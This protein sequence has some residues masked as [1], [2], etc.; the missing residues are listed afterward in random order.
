MEREVI[1]SNVQ[2]IQR[3]LEIIASSHNDDI[4]LSHFSNMDENLCAVLGAFHKGKSV[5]IKID[6]E[7]PTKFKNNLFIRALCPETECEKNIGKN[8]IPYF[9]I[10]K[11]D[12]NTQNQ[13]VLDYIQHY[14]LLTEHVP[15]ISEQV[16]NLLQDAILEFF[17][18]AFIHTEC[19]RVYACGRW[20]QTENKFH[21]TIVNIGKTFQE[22]VNEYLHK[23]F[24]SKEAIEWAMVRGNTTKKDDTGGLGLSV[25]TEF[26]EKNEGEFLLISGNGALCRH[27][28]IPCYEDIGQFFP[29]TF[30]NLVFNLKDTKQY[31]KT[32]ENRSTVNFEW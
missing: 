7:S 9:E 26:V 20:D 4:C 17:S 32:D 19:D 11:N 31:I 18:N 16:K 25:I 10:E 27:G 14:I 21:L 28:N 15:T 22:N 6:L 24:S 29:G 3:I 5:A 23:G 30:V 8:V 13:N 2:G 12:Y 1:K